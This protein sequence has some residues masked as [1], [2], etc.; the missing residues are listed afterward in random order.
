MRIHL[1]YI[2]GKY[3][4]SILNKFEMSDAHPVCVPADPNVKL[5]VPDG[6]SRLADR[7]MYQQIIGGLQYVANGTRPD[8][9]F[10][11]NALSRYNSAPTELHMTALKRVLRY[12]KGTQDLA[13]NYSRGTTPALVAF[14][15]ADWAGDTETR[16]STSGNV[17]LMCGAAVTWANR[18]QASVTLSTVEAEYMALSL[19]AQ[20][21]MWLRQFETEINCVK[22]EATLIWEDNTVNV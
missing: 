17:F 14:S 10:I 6:E 4:Q 22:P 16:K 15:D 3:I 1:R 11:V 2:S 19:A 7:N 9:A 13:L 21:A 5:N 8:F 20:E 12:L 18:K